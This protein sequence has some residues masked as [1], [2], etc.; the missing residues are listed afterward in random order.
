[1]SFINVVLIG[2]IIVY[3]LVSIDFIPMIHTMMKEYKRE[4]KWSYWILV[5]ISSLLWPLWLAIY[6][7]HH[8]KR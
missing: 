5:G 1:M 7:Y 4:Y 6:L 2:I 8:L 3:L